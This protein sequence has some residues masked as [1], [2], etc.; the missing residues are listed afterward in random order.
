MAGYYNRE[1]ESREA[2]TPDGGL[3]TGDMGYLDEDNY[4]HITGR[5]KEQYKLTNGKYVAPSALESALERSRFISSAVVYG[6]GK[7]YNVALIAINHEA[8]SDWAR[9]RGLA[10]EGLRELCLEPTVLELVRSEVDRLCSDQ[11][12]YARIRAF[13]LLASSFSQEDGLLTPSLKVRRHKVVERFRAE[14]DALYGEAGAADSGR[15][16]EEQLI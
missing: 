8:L 5:I 15:E 16:C 10:H 11:R 1:R 4:L 13:R 3:R 12:A 9:D 7:P 2:F 14:I 6:D